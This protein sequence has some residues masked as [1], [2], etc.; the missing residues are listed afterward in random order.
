MVKKQVERQIAD[1]RS[2]FLLMKAALKEEMTEQLRELAAKEGRASSL[3]Y[4]SLGNVSRHL[5]EIQEDMKNAKEDEEDDAESLDLEILS[6]NFSETPPDSTDSFIMRKHPKYDLGESTMILLDVSCHS[7]I[8]DGETSDVSNDADT[9]SRPA[10]C[11]QEENQ[12][13]VSDVAA[14]ANTSQLL[15]ESEK[16]KGSSRNPFRVKSSFM[17]QELRCEAESVDGTKEEEALLMERQWK[18][19]MDKQEMGGNHNKVQPVDQQK[20]EKQGEAAPPASKIQGT[21]NVK[22]VV[23]MT[24]MTKMKTYFSELIKPNVSYKWQRFEDED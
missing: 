7:D 24:K 21:Q 4:T 17:P 20:T 13:N 11:E 6:L 12:G 1:L 22:Q 23:T 16:E 9:S 15:K 8:S 5:R 18:E 2:E 14:D 10:K 3:Y 19:W